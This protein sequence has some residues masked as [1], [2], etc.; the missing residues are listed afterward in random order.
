MIPANWFVGLVVPPDGWFDA[1]PPVPR[2]TRY[3]HRDDLHVNLS[4][5][6][7]VDEEAAMRAWELSKKLSGG[8]FEFPLG[9]VDPVGSPRQP[10]AWAAMPNEPLHKLNEFL[11]MFRNDIAQAA[12]AR[13]D[14]LPPRP[15]ITIA[16]PRR[17]SSVSER[18][19]IA[20]WAEMIELPELTLQ[21]SE[22]ALYTWSDSDDDRLFR[23]VDRFTLGPYDPSLW[24]KRY[25]LRYL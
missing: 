10:S 12:R 25:T 16:R 6:G 24:P 7:A 21:L 9:S 15:S 3:C 19:Q 20:Q 14:M 23:I 1:L 18:T 8:P 5:L 13:P 22:V 17:F 4:F 11:A 2:G